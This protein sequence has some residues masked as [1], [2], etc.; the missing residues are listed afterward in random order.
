MPTKVQQFVALYWAPPG[1]L[2]VLHHA[3]MVLVAISAATAMACIGVLTLESL[4]VAGLV[5]TG[6]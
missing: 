2:G 3:K 5:I 4:I 6:M 1:T